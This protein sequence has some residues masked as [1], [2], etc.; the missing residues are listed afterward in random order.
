MMKRIQI[1]V[2]IL[3][4]MMFFTT[5]LTHN[6]EE[7]SMGMLPVINYPFREYSKFFLI[8]TGILGVLSIF[9]EI[10]ARRHRIDEGSLNK[11]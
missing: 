7:K 8:A 1:I 6:F 5:I 2:Y 4:V 11:R 9:L 10:M 3:I